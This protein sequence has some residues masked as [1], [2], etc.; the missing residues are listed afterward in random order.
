MRNQLAVLLITKQ[1]SQF[2]FKD[3]QGHVLIISLSKTDYGIR[4]WWFVYL[5]IPVHCASR[6]DGAEILSAVNNDT[7]NN[8]T[9]NNS[10]PVL[11]ALGNH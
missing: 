1:S 7:V 2:P 11:F 8:D 5:I 9:V 6:A 3:N 4:V 10:F